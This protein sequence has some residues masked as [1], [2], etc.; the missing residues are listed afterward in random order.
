MANGADPREI[1]G[2]FQLMHNIN[3]GLAKITA[4]FPSCEWIVPPQKKGPLVNGTG[5][6]PNGLY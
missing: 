2:L 4:S 5:A 1:T 3:V 6:L